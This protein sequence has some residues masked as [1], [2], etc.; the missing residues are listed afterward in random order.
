MFRIENMEQ[1][2]SLR[3]QEGK[4]LLLIIAD[5]CGVCDSVRDQTEK[6]LSE[7]PDIDGAF[8]PIAEL[9]EVAGEFMVFS[10]PTILIFSQGREI[11]RE[12]RFIDFLK[13]EKA[14]AE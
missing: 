6:M 12:S 13:L 11:A 8:V 9:P 14:L 5:Y 4:F 10:A 7:Y 1:A 3:E 2:K